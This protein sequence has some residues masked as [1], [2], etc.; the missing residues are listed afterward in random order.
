VGL[1]I[2]GG[3]T[4]AV[5]SGD[6]V[7]MSLMSYGDR[8]KHQYVFFGVVESLLLRFFSEIISDKYVLECRLVV[9]SCSSSSLS[10]LSDT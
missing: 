1:L 3:I 2:L 4:V 10:L 7:I 8:I 9:F 6:N 5:D